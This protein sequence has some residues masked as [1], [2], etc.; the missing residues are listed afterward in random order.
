MRMSFS[1]ELIESFLSTFKRCESRKRNCGR[2]RASEYLSF[3]LGG[4][5]LFETAISKI[6]LLK[7]DRVMSIPTKGLCRSIN[8]ANRERSVSFF[9]STFPMNLSRI[10]VGVPGYLF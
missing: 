9:F 3:L 7:V 6:I 8:S 2:S 4:Q 1:E 10:A 5:E